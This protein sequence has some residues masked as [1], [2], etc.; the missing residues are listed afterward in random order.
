VICD[1][2]A[3]IYIGSYRFE[4]TNVDEIIWNG[5]FVKL[6]FDSKNRRI[7]LIQILNFTDDLQVYVQ[8]H[9]IDKLTST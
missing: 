4:M 2:K 6:D 5:D 7:E 3:G 1:H 9:D 8:R